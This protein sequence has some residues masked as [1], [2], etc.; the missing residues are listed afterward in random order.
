MPPGDF[1]AR[2]DEAEGRIRSEAAA[3]ALFQVADWGGPVMVG[4]WEYHDGQ[5]AVVGLLHGNPDSDGP[6]VQVRTTTNDTMS[7]LI[8]LR[9]RLLGP[10]G[11]EDR[12]WQTL[13]AMTADPGIPATIPIDSKEVDFSIWQWTD[14]WWATATYAGHGI[15]IEA[16]RIDIDALALARI[17][18]IEPYLTGRREWLRQRRGEA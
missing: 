2:Y 13:S 10:A 4:E 15:V 17:E 12:P 3:V 16:E 6:V 11:D 9:M 14:R 5:L 8:G 7:D 18:D 1:W